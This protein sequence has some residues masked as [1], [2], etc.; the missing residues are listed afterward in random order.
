MLDVLIVG[1]GPHA[2]ILATLLVN[3]QQHVN[4]SNAE[5]LQGVVDS[6]GEWASL[7]KSQFTALN[8]P[9]LRSHMLVH[10]NPLNKKALQEFVLKEDRLAELHSLPERVYIQDENAFFNDGR[11]GK[12]NRKLLSATQGLQKNLY[13]SLPGTQLSVD[14]F[15][16]QVRSY[17]LDCVLLKGTVDKITPI[18]S[19]KEKKVE[20]FRVNLDTGETLEAKRVVLAT[21]PT[22]EH[23]GKY[24][25]VGPPS[26]CHRNQ[27]VMVIGGG[28]SSAH[29]ISMAMQQ[30]ASQ[31]T[32]VLRKH[33]QQ[34]DVG[35][36]ESL[37]GRY[38][39]IEHG[40]K[41]DGLAYLR[42]FYGERSLHKRLA[43]IKQARKGGAVTPE[44]Y[45]QLQPFI[46]SGQLL[47]KAY[48]QVL[49]GWPCIS[50]TL[51]WAPGCPV[52]LMGQY[53][54]LQVG[55]HAVNLA[56]GQAAALRIARNI[57]NEHS[58][59]KQN[60]E[61]T[62]VEKAR[63]EENLDPFLMLDEF[64]VKKPAGFPD[65]PHRGF[66]TVTYLLSGASAHED[67]CGH[68]GKLEAGDLQW[69]TAGRGVVHAEMPLSD[70]P[71]TGLQLW[72]NLRKTDKMVEPQYQE[73]KSKQVPK[74]SK[75]GVTVAVISGEALGVKSK[76][77]T[78]TPTIYLDF[79]LSEG[80]K[81]VQ[82][83]T[84]GWTAFIYTL[85][86]VVHVGP[87]ADLTKVE[88]HHTVVFDDGDCIRVENKAL[89]D[90]H[91]V[92][93]AGEP[94]K[95]PV[96]QHGPFVMNSNEEIQQTVSDYRTCTNGFERAK[97]WQSKIS[98]FM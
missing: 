59:E 12:Q 82:P 53:A 69:M 96:V 88:P 92:L 80:A 21:G 20:F 93:I 9:H 4:S 97:H 29:I 1:A 43:M 52:Y 46:Q 33:V 90:A 67:F 79:H 95:E 27:R 81:H 47:V 23:N 62:K 58:S 84:L 86:G 36:V 17:N 78:R 71:M 55:P 8:I 56:G 19:G 91:F 65:H 74:P 63:T 37:I 38:S 28:L 70:G 14:F 45:A 83:V 18:L 44:A 13:F 61:S 49:E 34:F 22:R 35:D 30:G 41:L 15:K 26:V 16:E 24:P 85:S 75:N 77:Y 64:C 7:W 48:C 10:T 87:E 25:S 40:I 6:Y 72:V 76:I 5:I 42:Q 98:G 54:A 89:E 39:H 50:E 2:L 11:L 68:S 32:W 57:I 3:P 31:V 94:I 73:L 51:Q 66:E 60:T